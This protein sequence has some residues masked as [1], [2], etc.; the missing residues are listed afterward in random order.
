VERTGFNPL[1]AV[2]EALSQGDSLILFPEGTRGPGDAPLPLKP[3]IFYLA[4][5]FPCVDLVPVWIVNAYRILPRGSAIPVPLL[6]PVRFGS[7]L[8]AKRGQQEEEFL[9]EVR[10]AVEALAGPD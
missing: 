5:R 7:P 9:S 2:A 10:E 4:R 6:C 3:G 1:E 8:R